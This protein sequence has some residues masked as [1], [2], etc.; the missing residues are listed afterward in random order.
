MIATMR[1]IEFNTWMSFIAMTKGV[2]CVANDYIV[3]PNGNILPE[4]P[5]DLTT[6]KKPSIIIQK[7]ASDVS[8]TCFNNGFIGQVF[9]DTQNAYVDVYSR[10]HEMEFQY[11][12]FGDTN[13]Q[14]GMLESLV[15][16]KILNGG[17]SITIYDFV[18]NPNTP[19]P[20]GIA[21]LKNN[22]DII[23]LDATKDYNYRTAI[24]FYSEVIQTVIPQQ[25]FVDL[26]KWMKISQTVTI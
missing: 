4:Y 1:A 25:E 9:D 15:V 24:R 23:P 16:D 18:S 17:E 10:K 11:D 2:A 12:L 3:V 5:R 14:N 22:L 6:F 21:R 20:M 19:T 13:T 8:A 7:V 26:S